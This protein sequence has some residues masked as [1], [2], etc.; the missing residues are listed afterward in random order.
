MACDTCQILK[1]NTLLEALDFHRDDTLHLGSVISGVSLTFPFTSSERE[2]SPT[3]AMCIMHLFKA[4][5]LGVPAIEGY[6]CSGEVIM[7]KEA[8]FSF[9]ICSGL[10]DWCLYQA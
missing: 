9:A 10:L 1:S 8:A 5:A 3:H 4:A 7:E 2:H 6:H